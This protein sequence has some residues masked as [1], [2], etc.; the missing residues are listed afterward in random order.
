MFTESKAIPREMPLE[1]MAGRSSLIQ[2]VKF[3]RN[4]ALVAQA[5]VQRHDLSSP[6]PPPLGFKQFTCLS[7][8]S[9][10]GISPCWSGWSRTPDIRLS[11]LLSLPKSWD[12]SYKPLH[13][14]CKSPPTNPQNIH[15]PQHH[16]IPI[17]KRLSF[18]MLPRLVLNSEAK[19]MCTPSASHRAGITGVLCVLL[20]SLKLWQS[21]SLVSN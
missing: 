17:L 14:A 6:Q 12:Y 5:G 1:K 16:I 13:L 19:S 20:V 9:R 7:L 11:A 3:Q 21:N 15:F 18:T 8:L 2:A 10:D 4:F